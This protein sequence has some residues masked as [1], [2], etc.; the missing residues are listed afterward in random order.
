MPIQQF[1]SY[2]MA[3]TNYFQWDDDDEVHFALDQHAE[4][5]FYIA[6][7]LKQESADRHGTPLW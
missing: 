2:I 6:S 3:R 7:S 1:V 5:G 4:L